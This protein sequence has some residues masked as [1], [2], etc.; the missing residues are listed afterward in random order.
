MKDMEAQMIVVSNG[1][2]QPTS[3]YI[4]WLV[5]ELL[6]KTLTTRMLWRWSPFSCIT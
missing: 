1:V 6:R 4:R 3:R 5:V 2:N